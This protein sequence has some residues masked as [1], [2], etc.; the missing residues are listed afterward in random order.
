M[1]VVIQ[2]QV[3]VE[4]KLNTVRNVHKEF[5]TDFI[6]RIG[7]F[8]ED[9]AFKDPYHFEVTK[10]IFNYRD[11]YVTVY[12]KPIILPPNLNQEKV[13]DYVK[14]MQRHDWKCNVL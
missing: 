1:L 11:N 3:Y 8:Y 10:V 13:I 2:Q 14:M 4:G 7:D 9:S 12:I 6:P 5:E